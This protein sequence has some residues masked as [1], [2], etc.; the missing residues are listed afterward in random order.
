MWEMAVSRHIILNT[1]TS[2]NLPPQQL[3]PVET[4]YLEQIFILWSV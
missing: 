4:M 2:E 1:Q 3:H